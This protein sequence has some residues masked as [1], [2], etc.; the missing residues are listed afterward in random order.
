MFTDITINGNCNNIDSNLKRLA[1]ADSFHDLSEGRGENY[2]PELF[3]TDIYKKLSPLITNSHRD[4]TDFKNKYFGKFYTESRESGLE[5]KINDAFEREFGLQRAV[6]TITYQDAIELNK[7]TINKIIKS[8]GSINILP[9]SASSFESFFYSNNDSTNTANL[10]KFGRFIKIFLY[11]TLDDTFDKQVADNSVNPISLLFDA[12]SGNVGNTFQVPKSGGIRYYTMA[13]TADSA[14]SS[15]IPLD[16]EIPIKYEEVTSE[17]NMNSNYITCKEV[18]PFYR[19]NPKRIFGE[20]DDIYCFSVNFQRTGGSMDTTIASYYF[21]PGKGT[22]GAGVPYIGRVLNTLEKLN[23]SPN[24]NKNIVTNELNKNKLET[25]G[26]IPFCD[27]EILK[28]IN[29]STTNTIKS[30]IN[31][32]ERLIVDYKRTGDYEQIFSVLR[33]VKSENAGN[34]T[35]C[36]VDLLASLCARMFGVPAIHQV[37]N[38]GRITLYRNDTFKGDPTQ[39][40]KFAFNHRIEKLK[41]DKEGILPRIKNY[42]TFLPIIDK[43]EKIKEKLKLFYKIKSIDNFEKIEILNKIHKINTLLYIYRNI[44]PEINFDIIKPKIDLIQNG[45]IAENIEYIEQIMDTLL[46]ID[47]LKFYTY[48]NTYFPQLLDPSL[49]IDVNNVIEKISK[50]NITLPQIGLFYTNFKTKNKPIVKIQGYY[51]IIG[52]TQK[53]LNK[54]I[55]EKEREI[56]INNTK[57]T[58]STSKKLFIDELTTY[59]NEHI[60]FEYKVTNETYITN[61]IKTV[62]KSIIKQEKSIFVLP[63]VGNEIDPTINPENVSNEL[64]KDKKKIEEA[65]KSTENTQ[66]ILRTSDNIITEKQPI[67]TIPIRKGVISLKTATFLNSIGSINEPFFNI[68]TY[69]LIIGGGNKKELNYDLIIGGGHQ[70]NIIYN[71]IHKILLN[72]FNRSNNFMKGLIGNNLKDT[73]DY[74]YNKEYVNILNKLNTEYKQE[75]RDFRL[76]LFNYFYNELNLLSIEEEMDMCDMLKFDNDQMFTLKI[77]LYMLTIYHDP[78]TITPTKMNGEVV[79]D[80]SETFC[81]LDVE[82][83]KDTGRKDLF[84]FV[85]L[86]FNSDNPSFNLELITISVFALLEYLYYIKPNKDVMKTFIKDFFTNEDNNLAA[87]YNKDSAK[88]YLTQNLQQQFSACITGIKIQLFQLEN[89]QDLLPIPPSVKDVKPQSSFHM[90]LRPRNKRKTKRSRSTSRSASRSASRRSSRSDSHISR[91]QKKSHNKTHKIYN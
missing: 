90:V 24:L 66:I 91:K 34:Y 78:S 18:L 64:E 35:F 28:I 7:K 53:N 26:R 67:E 60:E 12:A 62:E 74:I 80:D 42:L 31:L 56:K 10:L 21:G 68:K 54:L 47:A 48:V 39:Q 4:S 17:I 44:P 8:N 55:K 19:V 61:Y 71:R 75:I 41:R 33:K 45:I 82:I 15:N 3:N 23:K 36:T 70:E 81:M 52:L 29:T 76:E 87:Q 22:S 86:I 14:G 89:T 40:A 38:T 6:E 9:P 20:N 79:Y 5:P 13:N 84:G 43:I 59:L 46:N 83:M 50:G 2:S 51:K 30:E 58:L 77:L 1:I 27:S 11:G 32:L 65:I 73:G 85:F 25:A 16:P 72:G 49:I 63:K 69:D 88:N 37:G 57:Q